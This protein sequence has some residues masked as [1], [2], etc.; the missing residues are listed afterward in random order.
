MLAFTANSFISVLAFFLI[1]AIVTEYQTAF[2]CEQPARPAVAR[3]AVEGTVLCL[4]A[5]QLCGDANAVDEKASRRGER[6][7]VE[8]SGGGG[9]HQLFSCCNFS[10]YLAAAILLF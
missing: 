4:R 9:Q 2:W 6:R 7:G 5:E 8:Q 1:T 10:S 3:D